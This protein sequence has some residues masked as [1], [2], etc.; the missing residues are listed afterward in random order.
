MNKITNIAKKY[1]LKND[2]MFKEFFSRKSN[3][4]FLKSF[5]SAVLNSNV[6]KIEVQKD[7]V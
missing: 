1:T 2:T 4:K 7:R 5:L 3:E 6:T